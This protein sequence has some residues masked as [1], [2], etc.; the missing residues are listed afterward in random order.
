MK[1]IVITVFA[2]IPLT[3][4][5]F[6]CGNAKNIPEIALYSPD[7]KVLYD[8]IVHMDSVLFGAYNVCDL[9][10]MA[11]CF[12]EDIE[13]YHDKGGL[14]TNKDSIMAATEKNICGKVTRVLIAGS[15]EVYPIANYG[16]IEMGQHYFI[17]NREPKPD[18][19]SIGK[20][21]HTWKK[22][23]PQGTVGGEWKLTR[24]IS[25]H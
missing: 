15:I 14:M 16:A 24:V 19:P 12:S 20:F 4:S 9:S 11:S 1:R 18:H 3:V 7:S 5:F 13:F 6:G 2:F 8:S 21:V 25:L 10:T 22:E 23:N 17:N